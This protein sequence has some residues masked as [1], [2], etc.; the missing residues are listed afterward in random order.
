MIWSMYLQYLH[1]KQ[2][3]PSIG[4][5]RHIKELFSF[6]QI[7]I[8]FL[9]CRVCPSYR[10]PHS[11]SSGCC[12]CTDK[13]QYVGTQSVHVSLTSVP[14]RWC[15]SCHRHRWMLSGPGENMQNEKNIRSQNLKGDEWHLDLSCATCRARGQQVSAN[16]LLCL[17]GSP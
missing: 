1:N 12:P 16:P 15:Q 11:V 7:L 17:L 8:V 4:T 9:L 6:S 2:T 10:A 5:V 3:V 13:Q 14:G